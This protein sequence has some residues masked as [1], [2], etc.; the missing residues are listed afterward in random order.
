MEQRLTWRRDIHGD[1]IHTEI[2]YIHKGEIYRKRIR[3]ERGHTW[4]KD[5]QIKKT[6]TDK[7]S[8]DTQMEIGYIRTNRVE[9][10]IKKGYIWSRDIY[11]NEI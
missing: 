5:T 8:R 9:V 4:S 7:Q 6:H 2:R 11:G 10:Y 1:E 3:R